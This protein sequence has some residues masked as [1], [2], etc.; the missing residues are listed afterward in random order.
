MIAL[1][2]L[3]QMP[4]REKL[5]VMEALWEDLSSRDGDVEVPQWHKN[6]LNEREELIAQGKAQ[7]MDWE[8][9]K[10]QIADAVK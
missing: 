3:H 1:A 8:V 4:L 9:A 6:I 2:E 7:F 10:G 5:F